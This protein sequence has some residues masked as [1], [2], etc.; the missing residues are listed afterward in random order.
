MSSV[1]SAEEQSLRKH[2]EKTERVLD[3]LEA[4]LRSIDAELEALAQRNHQYELLEQVC[5]SLE[6]LDGLG[7]THLPAA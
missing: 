4:D 6:E 1:H 2:V 3:N 5:R 7:A